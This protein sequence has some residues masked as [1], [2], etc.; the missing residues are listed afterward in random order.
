M[1]LEFKTNTRLVMLARRFFGG[2]VHRFSCPPSLW[3]TG[4]PGPIY[5]LGLAQWFLSIFLV[6]LTAGYLQAAEPGLPFTED[7][8]D[9]NLK[10]ETKTNANWSPEEQEVYLAWR[11]VI[12]GAM[13][14]PEVWNLGQD[15][16]IKR[17]LEMGAED[18][19][20]KTDYTVRQVGDKVRKILGI[21]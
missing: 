10:D 12:Y 16:D 6:L 14:V 17:G 1:S 9:T 8:S 18:Y 2:P 13:S 21:N 5:K 20:I 7:F 19:L 15:S 3:R 11:K 4:G